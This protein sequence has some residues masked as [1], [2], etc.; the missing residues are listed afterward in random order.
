[1]WGRGREAGGWGGGHGNEQGPEEERPSPRKG[2][3]G[4]G[5]G[6]GIKGQRVVFQYEKHGRGRQ[7]GTQRN[8][9]R[10]ERQREKGRGEKDLGRGKE[11]RGGEGKRP[12]RSTEAG[13]GGGT[14]GQS[15]HPQSGC[16]PPRR[17]SVVAPGGLPLRA[18]GSHRHSTGGRKGRRP[19]LAREAGD[20]APLPGWCWEG[21]TRRMLP[22]EAQDAAGGQAGPR[23][24]PGCTPRGAGC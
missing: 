24:G 3:D 16:H 20:Q 8:L 5:Q 21:V 6:L 19:E 22:G 10:K 1:M 23:P 13:R 12:E 2:S 4:T 11:R 15:S 7:Y 17:L 14:D 9:K 18:P